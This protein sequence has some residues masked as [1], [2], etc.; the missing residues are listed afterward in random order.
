MPVVE[1][2]SVEVKD[3]MPL[4]VGVAREPL[5]IG[6]QLELVDQNG[7]RGLVMVMGVIVVTEMGDK[8]LDSAKPGQ[9]VKLLLRVMGGKVDVTKATA[10]EHPPAAKA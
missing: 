8:L 9:Q 6:S 3:G 5:M 2:K 1:I 7:G 10:L 4:P